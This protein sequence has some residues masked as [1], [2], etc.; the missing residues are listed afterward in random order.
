M[1]PIVAHGGMGG[2]TQVVPFLM[3]GVF[4]AFLA[5]FMKKTGPKKESNVSGRDR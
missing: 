4:L 3:P 5:Y 2:A 1:H